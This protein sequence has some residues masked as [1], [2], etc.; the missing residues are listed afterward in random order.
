MINYRPKQIEIVYSVHS[1]PAPADTLTVMF[2]GESLTDETLTWS[3]EH[4]EISNDVSHSCQRKYTYI[5]PSRPVV[6]SVDHIT[7]IIF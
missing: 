1:R 6:N 2:I 4:R 7:A 3:R 5:I